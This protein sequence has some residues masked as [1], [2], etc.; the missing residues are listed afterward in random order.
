MSA[1]LS[2]AIGGSGN[3]AAPEYRRPPGFGFSE[4]GFLAALR[5]RIRDF[6]QQIHSGRGKQPPSGGGSGEPPEDTHPA[7]IWDDAA[8]WMLM[9]H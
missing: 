1:R 8:L 2:I 6:W 9:L 7:T 5:A 3:V 4:S